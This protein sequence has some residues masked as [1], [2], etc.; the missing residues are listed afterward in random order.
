MAKEN[1]IERMDEEKLVTYLSR[2]TNDARDYIDTGMQDNWAEA[3]K[4]YFGE[5]LGNEKEG[6]SQVISRDVSDSIDWMMPSL[7]DIFCGSKEAV[8]FEP[9]TQEDVEEAEQATNYVN[10][11]FYRKN[12]GFM[13]M[14]NFLKDALMFKR[15]IVKHYFEEEEKVT[16]ELYSGLDEA[17]VENLLYEDNVE[18][19]ERT[20]VEDGTLDVKISKK[21]IVSQVKVEN[22]PPEEFLIDRFAKTEKDATFVAH[23][24]QVTRSDLVSLGYSD[25]LINSLKWGG[26][27]YSGMEEV[28]IIREK[29]NGNFT[30]EIEET[31]GGEA[32]EKV[33]LIE[34][35]VRIDFDGDGIAELRRVVFSGD[36]ILSNDEWDLIPFSTITPNPI[37]HVFYGQSVFDMVKD[38]QDVKT[39]LLRNQLDNMY[40]TN[41][42]R[43]VVVEG[44]VNLNDLQNN[45]AGGVVREK[46][47]GALRPLEQPPL[48]QGS[49]DMLGYM[50]ELKTN[51]TGVSSRSQGLDDKVL[52]SHTGQG[53][54]NKVMSVAEQRLKLIARIF[55]ETGITDLFANIY[56]LITKYQSKEDNFRLNGK[57]VKVNPSKW[58]SRTDLEIVVGMGTNDKDQ[59]LMHLG[60]L[61]ELQ[62]AVVNNGGRG[63]LTNETKIFNLLIEMTKNAGYKDAEK[64]W[65]DPSSEEGQQGIQRLQEQM[66]KPTPDDIKAN[67][68]A[69]KKQADA[70]VDRLKV[71]QE[72]NYKSTDS[73]IKR[74]ELL[75]KERELALKEREQGLKE[76]EQDLERERFEWEKQLN[77]AEVILEKEANRAVELGDREVKNK[78]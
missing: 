41:Q 30:T 24:R 56:K 53:Q 37:Q 76:D 17:D 60:R 38:V 47:Q 68:D 19:I 64:F 73:E 40:L 78:S 20:D 3:Q 57:F 26:N 50:D 25:S 45:T 13:I 54:V 77:T 29:F 48:P 75:L 4:Y 67:S 27:E 8:K 14:H 58:K 62:Q 42:G 6:K 11:V 65:L 10:Y 21:E 34:S 66:S 5:K 31:D 63:I 61:F 35:Y 74:Q 7:M 59:Q 49:Y 28:K 70:Q 1:K 72:A 55:A 16:T 52:N 32:N 33:W 36:T 2:L 18:L 71:Q 12:P 9:Q 51:R 46:M 43:Y 44:Q 15:G 69:S 39:A 22:V 23:R